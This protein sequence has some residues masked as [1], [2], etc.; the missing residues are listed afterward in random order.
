MKSSKVNYPDAALADAMSQEEMERKRAEELEEK[1]AEKRAEYERHKREVELKIS[2]YRSNIEALRARQEKAQQEID[3][4]KTDLADV[5]YKIEDLKAKNSGFEEK[6]QKTQ[7]YLET[8]KVDLTK[9]Q[10]EYQDRLVASQ[11]AKADAE[12][13]IYNK[14]IEIQRLKTQIAESETRI[15]EAEATR[16][17]LEAEEMK[18]RTVWMQTKLNTADKMNQRDQEIAAANEAKERHGKAVK[19]LSA[20]REELAKAEKVRAE[21]SRKASA[22]ISRYE[23]EIV[24]ATKSKMAAEA[25]KIRL[26]T[27]VNKLEDL[28]MRIKT[29]RDNA[30]E[31]SAEAAGMVLK[32][33]VAV[34]TARSELNGQMHSSDQA[35]YKRQKEQAQARGL[36]AA[37]EAADLFSGAR[38]WVATGRCKS[39]GQPTRGSQFVSSLGE[40]NRIMAREMGNPEWVEVI[41]GSGISSY[42]ESRCG[43]FEN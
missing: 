18:T 38:R 5:G 36:A 11:K 34:E 2:A 21:V 32:S 16:T 37:S 13:S 35:A 1:A 24:A 23:S 39:Y 26:E 33:R 15:R 3:S 43:R 12:T 31:E 6:A 17:E 22:D 20:A 29:N 40:G 14:S 27:E 10:K 41:N 30:T 4:V 9:Q 25:E 7:E 42:V 8:L 19:D 28:A